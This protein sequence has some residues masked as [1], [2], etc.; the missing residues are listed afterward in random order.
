MF[1]TPGQSMHH[2]IRKQIFDV[3]IRQDSHAHAIQER[4]QRIH[5][6]RLAEIIDEALSSVAGDGEVI[7]L[8]R[9][10]VE[11]G[12]ISLANLEE[13]LVRRTRGELGKVLRGAIA[14][15]Q[16]KAGVQGLA[17]IQRVEESR[18][19]RV[20]VFLETGS[21]PWWV[22]ETESLELED[23]LLQLTEIVPTDVACMLRAVLT[24]AVARR[25]VKQ[26]SPAMR[27]RLVAV[28]VP[29]SA[30]QIQGAIAD[31]GRLLKKVDEVFT[32]AMGGSSEA[33]TL[34]G[35]VYE[36]V[37]IYLGEQKGAEANAESLCAHLATHFF[38]RDG[39]TERSTFETLAAIAQQ[40]LLEDS[41]VRVW[42]AQAKRPGVA[43]N[44]L[45][46]AGS[47]ALGP[48]KS[49]QAIGVSHPSSTVES[50]SHEVRSNEI[51]AAPS[52]EHGSNKASVETQG[53]GRPGGQPRAS[54][55]QSPGEPTFIDAA[56][57]T[58]RAERA[59]EQRPIHPE[60]GE[61][62]LKMAFGFQE[63]TMYS[64]EESSEQVT[65]RLDRDQTYY[66]ENAGLV[67][68]WPY[69]TRF[70]RN[71]GLLK[72]KAFSL[73]ATREKA[74]LVLQ[75]LA[76]GQAAWPEHRLLLNKLLC[77]WPPSEPVA[78]AVDLREAD[79]KAANELLTAIIGHWQALKRTSVD[80]L[81]RAFLQREGRITRQ[82]NGWQLKVQRVS[83]DVL[84]D[85]LPWGIGLVL[86]PWMQSPVF[87]EW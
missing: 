10:D 3:T 72:D 43:A 77:G 87:V 33:S 47:M 48:W 80:G 69:L 65:D 40:V 75:H 38:V 71:I 51:E 23:L 70:F 50:V 39:H 4:L 73:E 42:F 57:R 8:D 78:K 18:L 54:E 1:E 49:S 15:L 63:E 62:G 82:E 5:K 11:L 44:P 79:V 25:I 37:L 7:R 53:T 22:P 20:R 41:P 59:P 52:P 28:L 17:R 14:D 64:G 61:K 46:R 26:F 68:L 16:A 74:V 6:D 12:A 66:I 36:A 60:S 31:W 34:S 32:T 67:I 76:T 9:I 85:R 19:A 2:V 81:R 83:Y 13:Q 27:E 58:E 29:S 56:P 21:L 35:L 30:T 86:L 55:I 84:L 24:P 45:A